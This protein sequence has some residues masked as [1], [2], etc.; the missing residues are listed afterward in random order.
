MAPAAVVAQRVMAANLSDLAAMG[1]APH[2]FLLA[3]TMPGV[4][5]AWLDEFTARLRQLASLYDIPLAGGNLCRGTLS[6]TMTVLGTA[7][8]GTLITRSGA[9]AGDDIY[10]TGCI[11]D[12]GAGLQKYLQHLAA[13]DPAT[14]DYLVRRYTEPLP[15]IEAGQA[16]RPLARAMIDISDGLLADL[17]H[18]LDA[19]G[20]G[21]EF[22]ITRIP[23]SDEL[24]AA[25][26]SE[27]KSEAAPL[28]ALTSGDDYELCFT[29]LPTHRDAIQ[30]VARAVGVKMTWL[31]AVRQEPDISVTRNGQL[32]Q[33]EHEGYSHFSWE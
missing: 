25:Y 7:P 2:S 8:A 12:A 11:G 10:V 31:G 27:A 24:L 29:A 3:L 16:L 5:V 23:L 28:A 22:D 4:D 13:K 19:S 18:L 21:A 14:A 20:V 17:R 9:R 33:L 15:R 1:A 6:L 26:E 32:L 30:A